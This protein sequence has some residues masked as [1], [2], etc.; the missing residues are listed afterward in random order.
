MI[1]PQY[2][3]ASDFYGNFAKIGIEKTVEGNKETVY[4]IIDKKG[5]VKMTTKY[6]SDIEYVPEYDLWIINDQLYDSKLSK[7]SSDGV[8]VNYEDEGYFTW[9]NDSKKTAGI[10]NKSGKITY[11]YKF[12]NG[13]SFLSVD[14]SEVNEALKERY[15]KVTIENKKYGI[16]NC[17]TGKV[18]YNYASYYLTEKDDNVFEISTKDDFDFV[19]IMYI[20]NDKIIY[21]SSSEDVNIEYDGNKGVVVISDYDKEYNERYSYVDISTGQISKEEPNTSNKSGLSSD[22][23][24]QYTKLS[25]FSCDKGYGLMEG[26]TIKIPCEWSA[27]WHFNIQLHKYLSS[28]GKEYVMAEKNNKTYL[29]NLK[30][31]KSVAEFNSANV[32]AE[33]DSTFICYTDTNTTEDVVY[34]LITGKS[35]SYENSAD[36]YRYTNYITI[37]KDGK[38]NY[39]NTDLKLI[40]T[41]E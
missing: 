7:I 18:I 1:Q 30:D 36:L 38:I 39:Y 31:G 28:K 34:N 29:L 23:W 14:P 11:T 21:Q 15:C 9:E 40:Y 5:N 12:A 27:I 3:E 2:D 10:M 17:D 37:K 41:E 35:L 22:E 4:Q 8:E 13:E 6:S 25:M 33:S 24:E 19:S 20:Q 26:E 16:V 32:S